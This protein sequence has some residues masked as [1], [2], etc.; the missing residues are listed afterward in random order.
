MSFVRY[1]DYSEMLLNNY[2]MLLAACKGLEEK[3]EAQDAVD[4][5][6]DYMTQVEK[7]IGSKTTY[8]PGNVGV[9]FG[10]LFERQV[11]IGNVQRVIDSIEKNIVGEAIWVDATHSYVYPNTLRT[12]RATLIAKL[13][14]AYEAEYNRFPS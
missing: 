1:S 3:T 12:K 5:M 9:P 2:N 11:A 4:A 13:Y 6:A 14:A 8:S 10:S 7:T